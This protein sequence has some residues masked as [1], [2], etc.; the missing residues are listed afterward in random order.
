M[1][2]ETM[3]HRAQDEGYVALAT[4][5]R[6]ESTE[7]VESMRKFLAFARR[8]R[9]QYPRIG[10]IVIVMPSEPSRPLHSGLGL[11]PGDVLAG[12]TPWAQGVGPLFHGVVEVAF[13]D[14]RVSWAVHLPFDLDWDD[15]HDNDVQ[16]NVSRLLD[17]LTQ[18]GAR[19]VVGDYD[20]KLWKDGAPASHPIKVAI[21]RFVEKLIQHYFP[22]L[23]A[24][25][26]IKLKRWRSEFFGCDRLLCDE[27]SANRKWLPFDPI[28]GVL[29]H[30]HRKGYKIEAPDLGKFYELPAKRRSAGEGPNPSGDELFPIT[31]SIRDQ[32]FRVAAQ[33][34]SLYLRDQHEQNRGLS[35]MDLQQLAQGEWRKKVEAGTGMA[36]DAFPAILNLLS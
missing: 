24:E 32:V 9:Q 31:S 16:H 11:Q 10:P 21:E 14:D 2:V 8:Q 4:T 25:F 35:K 22:V 27:L 30:C 13:R 17:P 34:E 7:Q 28:P 18:N 15:T 26:K 23:A 29:L 6:N 19:F 12:C 33:M 1:E 5:P 36:F 3:N 20:P